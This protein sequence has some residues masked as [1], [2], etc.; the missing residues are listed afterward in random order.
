MS[1]KLTLITEIVTGVGMLPGALL[2]TV[3]QGPCRL[4]QLQG[5]DPETWNE[6]CALWAEGTYAAAFESAFAHGRYF[7]SA[8]GG[9]RGRPPVKVEW[10][11]PHKPPEHDPLP[12]DLRVDDV[13]I[14]SCKNDSKV[15][16]NPSPRA[17]FRSAL[18][19]DALKGTDW[20]GEIAPEEYNALY[21]ACVSM[22]GFWGFPDSPLGLTKPQRDQLKRQFRRKWPVELGGEVAA[23]NSAVS[24]RSAS[25]LNAVIST[26][27]DRE[28]FYW[29]LLRLH[30]APY[31]ILGT[32]P[33]GP[34][35]LRVLTPWDFR[36]KYRFAGLK[37]VA[38]DVG[39]P[40]ISWSAAFVDHE[41]D[42]EINTRGHVEIRWSH[43]KFCGAPE[44]KIYLD[45]P[46]VDACGYQAI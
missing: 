46:H 4:D 32:Q 1:A 42:V 12:A 5:V 14:V 6:L 43:G 40:Q 11:G 27:A 21:A 34:I 23:F 16:S 10:K 26:K 35:R 45:T 29:R 24:Q 13:Y 9:L 8:P 7:L 41:Q 19:S 38:D 15:L 44:A 31:F 36:R 33:S 25:A 39:Q 30:S 3:F 28:H 20:Y 37:V 2:E 17:L 22:A 18:R